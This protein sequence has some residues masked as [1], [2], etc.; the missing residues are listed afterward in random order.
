V[1]SWL[2]FFALLAKFKPFSVN[3]TADRLGKHCLG[4]FYF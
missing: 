2:S 1:P 3:R 4:Y